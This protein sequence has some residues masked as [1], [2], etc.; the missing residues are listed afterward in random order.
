MTRDEIHESDIG[1]GAGDSVWRLL[2]RPRYPRLRRDGLGTFRRPNPGSTGSGTPTATARSCASPAPARATTTPPRSA[3]SATRSDDDGSVSTFTAGP[4]P[5][6]ALW[7]IDANVNAR[8]LIR[9]PAL[10]ADCANPPPATPIETFDVFWHTFAENYPFFAQHGV[11]WQQVYDTYRSQVS[12]S[13]TDAQL[14]DIF[15]AMIKPLYDAHVG[16][17][18]GDTRIYETRPGTQVPN[19]DL[20]KADGRAD[21]ARGPGGRRPRRCKPGARVAS[22]SPRCRATSATC[23]SR[24]SSGSRRTTPRRRTPSRSAPP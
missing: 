15:A 9:L 19:D 7:H 3:A 11:D 5:N 22:G 2:A 13:T 16:V 12:A 24:A 14:R 4:G 17:V 10:P 21:Q 8:A 6:R 23:G 1:G 18:A 20:E